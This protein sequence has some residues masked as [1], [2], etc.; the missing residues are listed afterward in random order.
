MRL[1]RIAAIALICVLAVGV[2]SGCHACCD[3]TDNCCYPPR[4]PCCFNPGYW[5]ESCG[6]N[7]DCGP[8]G[9]PCDCCDP[10]G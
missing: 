1:A 9:D 6:P 4:K 7:G 8:L 3:K 2:L 5:W 10:K